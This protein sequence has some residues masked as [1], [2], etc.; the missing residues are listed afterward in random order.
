M[1][2][3]R[4]EVKILDQ[5]TFRPD[6]TTGDIIRISREGFDNG[7][8]ETHEIVLT[9]FG[10][11]KYDDRYEMTKYLCGDTTL[12]FPKGSNMKFAYFHSVQFMKHS[13]HPTLNR[14]RTHF[15]CYRNVTIKKDGKDVEIQ[16][17]TVVIAK[18]KKKDA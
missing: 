17:P 2:S 7:T 8:G 18:K 5:G 6:E 15:L 3:E 10:K 16:V 11:N 4:T 9:L 13:Q 12:W 1:N 14:V